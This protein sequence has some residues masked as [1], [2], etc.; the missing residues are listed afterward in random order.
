MANGFTPT[1]KTDPCPVCG[2]VTGKCRTRDDN[3]ATYA[4]CM[5]NGSVKLH[6]VVNGWKC[7]KEAGNQ[8]AT[9]AQVSDEPISAEVLEQRRRDREQRAAEERALYAA[10]L[11]ASD[12]NVAHTAMLNQLTLHPADQA[13]LERRDLPSELIT[14]FKSI[15]PWQRFTQ[16]INPKAPCVSEDGLSLR[17]PHAGYLVPARNA[18]GQILGFQV[19]LRNADDGG[20]YRWLSSHSRPSKMRNAEQP[21]TIA[22]DTSDK[23][24]YMCEGIGKPMFS[25][26]LHSGTWIGAAGGNFA[27]SPQQFIELTKKA[28]ASTQWIYCPDGGDVVNPQVMTRLHRQFEFFNE[29]GLKVK[30]LWWGQTAKDSGDCDEIS[31]KIFS[32]AKLISWE[33]FLKIANK[34]QKLQ[35]K[36]EQRQQVEAEL[37]AAADAWEMLPNGVTWLERKYFGSSLLERIQAAG[38]QRY[39]LG[40]YGPTGTGKTFGLKAIRQEAER[41]GRQFVYITVKETLARAAA[42]DLGLNYR[43]DLVDGESEPYPDLAGCAAS[44][45]DN[46]RGI[47]WSRQISDRATVVLDEIDLFLS[48][49]AGPRSGG[50]AL[51]LQRVLTKV[52][53][54]AQTVVIMSAQIKSRHMNLVQRVGWFQSADLVGIKTASAPKSITLADD[55]GQRSQDDELEGDDDNILP[56]PSMAKWVIDR[57]AEATSAGKKSLLLSGAQKPDSKMGTMLLERFAL[58][59]AGAAA[60]LRLDS[61]STKDPKNPAFQIATKDYVNIMRRYQTVIASPSCQEGFSLHFGERSHFDHVFVLDP[62]NKLPDQLIQDIGRDRHSTDTTVLVK[63]GLGQQMFNGTVDPLEIRRQMQSAAAQPEQRLLETALGYSPLNWDND[64]LTFYCQDVAQAN[65]ALTDKVY[66]LK[67]YLESVGHRVGLV[68]PIPGTQAQ[69]IPDDFYE[70]VA[71]EYHQA[72]ASGRRFTRLDVEEIQNSGEISLEQW[73]GIQQFLFRQAMAWD[74]TKEVDPVTGEVITLEEPATHGVNIDADFIRQWSRDRVAKPWQMYFYA[75]QSEWD[76]FA[77]DLTRRQHRP[78]YENRDEHGNATTEIDPASIMGQRSAKLSLLKELGIL[79]FMNRWTID[80]A[81]D[82]VKEALNPKV[83]ARILHEQ[84]QEHRF[85]KADLEPI[86]DK[87]GSRFEEVCQLLGVR[88]RRNNDGTVNHRQ[89]LTLIRNFF[90]V[91]TFMLHSSLN[92]VKGVFVLVADDKAQAL[93]AALLKAEKSEDQRPQLLERARRLY[94]TT[95]RRTEMFPIWTQRLEVERATF[96]KFLEQFSYKASLLDNQ[97]PNHW[98]SLAV[99]LEPAPDPDIA[100]CAAQLAT[101]RNQ[102]GYQ[103]TYINHGAVMADPERW[104]KVWALLD[105]EQQNRIT[106]ILQDQ[107]QP[108]LIQ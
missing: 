16:A 6:E 65:A 30:I 83:M 13:D 99:Y 66:N 98:G 37:I 29:I 53:Q 18:A 52:L 107:Q 71:G 50:N 5:V 84:H 55:S 32:K 28:P 20:R 10:G 33:K 61:Q 77:S 15:E 43:L 85:T 42:I 72:V 102:I 36:T 63:N 79:D 24:R 92:G 59:Q 81:S 40:V 91:K 106:T 39:L 76:W 45:I 44:L 75:Q 88:S 60:V 96:R 38:N 80:V 49:V 62:G 104:A 22:G 46:A 69:G 86:V 100:A 93:R 73:Y 54:A 103:M 90:Q 8:W 34:K 41:Q 101:V 9:F 27:S 23:I 68:A 12:R 14:Q 35:K 11:T 95:H 2:D 82:K 57:W 89:V 3:G 78:I 26:A 56:M 21:I 74:I 94:E 4:L 17:S 87:L 48:V 64:Y 97:R 58:E 51:E 67:R 7:V 108:C 1:R 70:Q 19:R 47:D 31:S 25:A 105:T